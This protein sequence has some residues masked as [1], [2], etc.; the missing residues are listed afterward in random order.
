MNQLQQPQTALTEQDIVQAAMADTRRIMRSGIILLLIGLGGFLLWA[1]YAPLDEGVP[2]Q[3]VV[4]IDTKRKSIQHLSGGIVREVYVREGDQVVEGQI[5]VT[6]EPANARAKF[7]SVRQH[8]YG[9]RAM[10]GRLLAE[11]RDA[12][13]IEFH[14]DLNV[15]MDQL[16][17]Q[18]QITTQRQLFHSRREALNATLA[19][20]KTEV[21]GQEA[22]IEG[23]KNVL[24]QRGLQLQLLR[25]ELEGI[26]D[27][28][29]EGYVAR[30]KKSEL[31][32]GE[33]DL[34]ASI[35]D[36]RARL[37]QTKRMIDELAQK[38][39]LRQQEYR[40]EVEGQLAEVR[41]EVQADAEKLAAA[42]EELGR[43]DLRAPATGQVVGLA[44]Q[45]V[46]A[47]VQPAEKLMDIVP[48]E[49][50][51][52]LEAQIPPHLSDRVQLGMMADIRFSA[53]AHSP[54]LVVDG[55]LKSMSQDLLTDPETRMSY[56]LARLEITPEGMERLGH[57][58]IVP[59][60]PAEVVIKTGE[61]SLLT[62]L[63]H[64]LLR[65]VAQSMTEE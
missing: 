13:E 46:G 30:S 43:M 63:L 35:A 16:L 1:A 8:Y 51:L 3:G 50:H 61:R 58:K 21:A 54:Q 34:S 5:L 27:L 29:K 28:V 18:Q 9:V 42:K 40:K 17:V 6:L 48:N 38:A 57:R 44:I 33:A 65:R 7:E 23:L 60:M 20:I 4:S 36:S 26:T 52:L 55:R 53:F 62:Y 45:T 32:R 64:P 37:E 22:S 10:E 2:T 41:R 59:G 12:T 56:Y 25:Q 24:I 39:N 11:Q 19:S 49:A 15:V 47:V 14:P 31:E